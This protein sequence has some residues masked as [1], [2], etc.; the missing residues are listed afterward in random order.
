MCMNS[1]WYVDLLNIPGPENEWQFERLSLVQRVRRAAHIHLPSEG[2]NGSWN[3]TLL[4]TKFIYDWYIVNTGQVFPLPRD[5]FSL[6]RLLTDVHTIW[7][8]RDQTHQFVFQ[9]TLKVQTYI[10]STVRH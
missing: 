5:V 9:P 2:K 8:I 7:G 1:G 3:Y 6:P 10:L 4:I